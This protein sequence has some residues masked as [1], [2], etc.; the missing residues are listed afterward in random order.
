[1]NDVKKVV[2]AET[3]RDL[4]P[5]ALHVRLRV[6]EVIVLVSLTLNLLQGYLANRRAKMNVD[7]MKSERGSV[8]ANVLLWLL[9]V[10]LPLILLV[11]LLRSC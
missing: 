10:P 2:E 5:R 1:M 4:S 9:G 3:G 8:G 6:V 7:A 11:S